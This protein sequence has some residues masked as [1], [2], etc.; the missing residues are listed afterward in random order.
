[1]KKHKSFT[2]PDA[3]FANKKARLKAIA[4]DKPAFAP[5]RVFALKPYIVGGLAAAA[6]LVVA[7]FVW[8]S[9]EGS[10]AKPQAPGL[11][12]I[13]DKAILEYLWANASLSEFNYFIVEEEFQEEDISLE[14]DEMMNYLKAQ[15]LDF[16]NL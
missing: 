9:G 11:T 7:F 1:M 4:E 14:E 16:Y 3:Y 10:P 13:D 12:Q 6:M 8:P 15:P 5:P 2:I